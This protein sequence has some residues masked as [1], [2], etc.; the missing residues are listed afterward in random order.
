MERE[1]RRVCVSVEKF[2]VKSGYEA[3]VLIIEVKA[4]RDRIV[5]GVAARG[6][7]GRRA[8]LVGLMDGLVRVVHGTRVAGNGLDVA[9]A[10][11]D[12]PTGDRCRSVA[13]GGKLERVGAAEPAVDQ[14]NGGRAAYPQDRGRNGIQPPINPIDGR[15]S[16]AHAL[17]GP[18]NAQVARR[19]Y[20]DRRQDLR[21]RT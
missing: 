14:V 6:V 7:G 5:G 15:S 13:G 3:L 12:G 1:A 16:G 10:P 21:P 11:V 9:I 20:G 19:A 18:E 8:D 4:H 2:L 17:P